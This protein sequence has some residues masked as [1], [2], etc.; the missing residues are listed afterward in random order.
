M[1][2]PKGLREADIILEVLDARFPGETRIPELER[3]ATRKGKKIILVVNKVDLVGKERAEEIK[4][5]LEKEFPTVF[6][7]ARRRWGSRKLRRKIR[8]LGGGKVF[9]VGLPNV[10]KSSVINLLKG[11]HVAGTGAHA[12]FTKG[13]QLVRISRDIYLVDTPG[14]FH[15]PPEKLALLGAY[16]PEKLRDP[17][18]VARRLL[19]PYGIELEDLALRLG[20]I[21]RGGEP[22][23]RNTAVFILRKNAQDPP[24]SFRSFL[25]RTRKPSGQG[26]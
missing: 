10:G 5:E 24:E 2:L 18:E 19:E 1:K 14:V 4:K 26:G 6:V 25:L 9:V 16:N 21:K 23:T 15:G 3:W 22:D 17:E 12:G 20:K 13:P 8:E 11:K 7:S